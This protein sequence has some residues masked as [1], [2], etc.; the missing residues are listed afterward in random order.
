MSYD[1]VV[2]DASTEGRLR[3]SSPTPVRRAAKYKAEL[4]M[5]RDDERI[6]NSRVYVAGKIK[7]VGGRRIEMY[8]R[9]I[10]T[11]DHIEG[12]MRPVFFFS[13]RRR[14]TRFDC[15]WSSDVCSSDLRARHL[16][17]GG[18]R[19]QRLVLAEDHALEVALQRLQLAAV[20]V[21]HVGRRNARDLGHDGLDRSE[22]R[23]VGKECRSRWSP[24]H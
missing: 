4:R 11:V 14:H 13:S 6:D 9:L 23:R 5:C 12:R 7:V 2:G 3:R 8:S 18:Q 15:D 16:D 10:H 17:R 24:Y 19:F 21:G 20:V 1:F 22:E